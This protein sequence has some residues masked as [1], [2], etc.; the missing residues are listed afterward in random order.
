MFYNGDVVQY[1]AGL[2]HMEVS[3]QPSYPIS[4]RPPKPIG[5]DGTTTSI[6]GDKEKK[7]LCQDGNVACLL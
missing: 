4:E 2:A 3:K 5:E 7:K 6:C 1:M